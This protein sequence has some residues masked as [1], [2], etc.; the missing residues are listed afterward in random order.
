MWTVLDAGLRTPGLLLSQDVSSLQGDR[1]R[2]EPFPRSPETA[3]AFL[4]H[5]G[6]LP[7]GMLL[8]Q[9]DWGVLNLLAS[10][11][12]ADCWPVLFWFCLL[13]SFPLPSTHT[14]AVT[15]FSHIASGQRL[16]KRWA[17]EW[18]EGGLQGKWQCLS[19][20]SW[21]CWLLCASAM[22]QW[23]CLGFGKVLGGM[24]FEIPLHRE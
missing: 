4:A 21:F 20:G 19:P 17:W 11:V 8:C 3:R 10:G 15:P 18:A 2:A 24:S 9:R 12:L 13:F 23:C 1:K 16:W 14:Y 22:G 5:V 6:F 7:T